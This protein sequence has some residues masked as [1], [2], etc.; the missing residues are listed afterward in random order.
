MSLAAKLHWYRHR[1]GAMSLP[2][3]AHRVKE[4]LLRKHDFYFSGKLIP[5]RHDYGALP[6]IPRLRENL[7]AWD[8]PPP[9]LAEWRDA[10][11]KAGRGEFHLLN[12]HWPHCPPHEKWHMDPVTGTAWPADQ[13]CF[14]VDFRHTQQKGDVKYVWELNRLQYLHPVAALACKTRDKDLSLF[15]LREIESWIDANP[16]HKG[17]NWASGIELALRTVSILLVISLTGEHATESQRMKI[18]QTLEAHAIWLERYPSLYSSANNHRTAEGL[19]IF[20]IGALCPQLQSS[21]RWNRYG[22]NVVCEM[23]GQ[24]VLADGVGAEQ[25]HS[26]TAAIL[27]MFLLAWHAARHAGVSIPEF[28][29]PR[30]EKAALCLRW[31][32]D[33]GGR[34]PHIGD[35]DNARIIGG[36]VPGELYISSMMNAVASVSGDAHLASPWHSYHL[37]QALF[38]FPPYASVSPEGMKTFH[39]GGY[40]V[41]RHRI[42]HQEVLL[43]MDHGGVGYLSI[44]A[45]GHADALAVWAHIGD[46]PVLVDAGNYLY[47]SGGEWRPY[48]RS[49][50][51]HNTLCVEHTDSSIMSGNFNWSHKANVQVLSTGKKEE[52]WW[53]E[54]EHD[55]Y[56]EAFGVVHRRSL[57]VHPSQG[58]SVEDSLIGAEGRHVEINFHL[59]PDVSAEQKDGAI[60]IRK[61]RQKLLYVKHQSALRSAVVNADGTGHGWYSPAFGEKA[62]SA[63]ITF[64]GVLAIGQTAITHFSF[65]I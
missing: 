17:V 26:Y 16:A 41:G 9:L 3:I 2:E 5:K 38:G 10:A 43:A 64:S 40:T 34:H 4:A 31:F 58:F 27:E 32:T 45:H 25:S 42:N 39:E 33:A 23:L 55:G 47:H 8:V 44:A 57:Q 30:L 13:Y 51:A 21:A 11:E 18:W 7:S 52:G 54:A 15:C 20:L 50:A 22:W 14:A 28:Y 12:Q 49:T 37:R 24:Q 36:Y 60:L 61:G 35:E 62:P 6:E 29:L 1:L 48:F 56:K 59:H 46:Q 65:L 53:V 63:R 19:G